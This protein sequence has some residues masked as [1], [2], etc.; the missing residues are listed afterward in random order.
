TPSIGVAAVQIGGQTLHA[1][2]G[3]KLGGGS[4]EQLIEETL[5][6]KKAVQRWRRIDVLVIDE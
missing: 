4:T 2:A 5:T 3:V 6:N 1:F